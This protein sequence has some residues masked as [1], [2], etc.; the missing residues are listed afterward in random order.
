MAEALDDAWARLDRAG[1]HIDALKAEIR[2]F[3]D[4][5]PYSVTGDPDLKSGEYVL[6]I[7]PKE[8]PRRIG[9]LIGD[10]LS[11]LRPALDYLVG[12]LA[13]L[14]SGKA[15]LEPVPNLR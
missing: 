2:R 10:V 15:H 1:E 4:S 9:V 5:R 11:N 7:K 13:K 12:A 6:R 8:P 3:G 14:D